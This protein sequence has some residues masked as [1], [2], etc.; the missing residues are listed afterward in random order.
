MHNVLGAD[1]SPPSA[2][3]ALVRS[4]IAAYGLADFIDRHTVGTVARAADGR[5]ELDGRW[6]VAKV[7]LATG[8]QDVPPPI[9]GGS[10]RP[11]LAPISPRPPAR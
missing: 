8:V 2:F 11:S 4:Q 3:R 5:F 6:S 9:P 1:G 10:R 7:V